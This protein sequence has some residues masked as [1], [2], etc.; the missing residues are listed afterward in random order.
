MVNLFDALIYGKGNWKCCLKEYPQ[1][2][3]VQA[4]NRDEKETIRHICKT[5]FERVTLATDDMAEYADIPHL[6]KE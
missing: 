2:D 3:D 4:L 6:Y 1:N 5:L